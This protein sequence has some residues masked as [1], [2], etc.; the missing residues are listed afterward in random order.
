MKRVKTRDDGGG[1]KLSGV[2]DD[3]VKKDV[4]KRLDG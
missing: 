1:C 4:K 2:K 3:R